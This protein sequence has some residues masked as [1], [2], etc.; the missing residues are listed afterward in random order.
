[1]ETIKQVKVVSNT[2]NNKPD[3]QL[4]VVDNYNDRPAQYVKVTEK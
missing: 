1:M 4:K 2:N 3:G